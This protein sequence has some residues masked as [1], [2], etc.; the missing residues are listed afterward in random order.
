MTIINDFQIEFT[1]EEV[2]SSQRKGKSVS[3]IIQKA[4]EEAVN[5]AYQLIK[6]TLLYDWFEVLSIEEKHVTLKSVDSD[7]EKRIYVGP[8]VNELNDAREVMIEVHTIGP[9]L[10]E[11]VQTLN[12]TGDML[13]GYLLDCAGVVALGKVNVKAHRMIEQVAA[14]KGWGVG[15]SLSPGSLRGW[16][17]NRQH[18][19]CSM[20]DLRQIDVLVNDSNLLIPLKSVSSMIGIG[21]KYSRK[22]VGS[23]CH[24]CNLKDTCWRRKK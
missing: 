8:Y 2:L 11:K 12:T 18:E 3:D 7:L 1:T 20:L 6:P 16:S 13:P 23:M 21:P 19:L 9:T 5:L 15:A 17:V 14:D 24:L 22:K 4:T 10:E